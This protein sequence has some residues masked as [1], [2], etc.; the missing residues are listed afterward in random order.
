[1]IDNHFRTLLPKYVKPLLKVY[2]RFNLSPNQITLLGLALAML[3]AIAIGNGLL[4]LGI[5]VWW[6]SRLLDGTD[7]IY[8]RLRKMDTPFG[9]YLDFV[10]DMAAYGAVILGFQAAFPAHITLWTSIIYLYILCSVS[11]LCFGTLEQKLNIKNNDNRGLR[12]GAGL[13]E[14]GETGIAY[15]AMAILPKYIELIAYIWLG[16]L[17][18]TVLSRSALA[19]QIT[20][21]SNQG[22]DSEPSK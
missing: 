15:T 10:C 18:F 14:A 6:C 5:C 3:A 12:L 8:A 17:I 16:I 1:M 11:A 20:R 21:Q 13:A 19:Y 9:A 7:G 2:A 22:Q 4:I